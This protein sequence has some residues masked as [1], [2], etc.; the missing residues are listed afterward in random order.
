MDTNFFKVGAAERQDRLVVLSQNN[1]L[2]IFD[3]AEDADGQ[4][5]N[6]RKY[7]D[8]VP[9]VAEIRADIEAL[10]NA[11]TDGKILSG[12][13]WNDTP[14]YLSTENQFNFKAAYDLAVQTNGKTLPVTFKLG[15]D[16]E[17]KPMYHT[18][19]NLSD[20]TD[21]YTQAMTH[22]VTTLAEGWQRK[23]SIDYSNYKAE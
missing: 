2:I 4:G 14:V 7:Y 21:F 12:F 6:Y 8:H 22:V 13:N 20:F 23:D 16:A 17:G 10:I 5:F 11:Q 15:E 3:Y 18:F 1:S 9:T 19:D